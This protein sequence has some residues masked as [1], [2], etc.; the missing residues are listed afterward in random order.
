MKTAFLGLGAIGRP[1]AR[2]I[3]A[4]GHPLTVWNRTASRAAELANTPNVQVASTPAAAVRDADVVITCLS[5]S[6]DVEGL[7]DG[8]DGILRGLAPNA[9]L[10]DCTSGEPSISKRIAAR[11]AG[12][13]AEFLDA[14]V[15]GGVAG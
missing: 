4:A 8:P 5:N 1:M 9:V 3:A 13:G 14:P 7:L 11:L 12:A 6:P 10:V 2:C 15:S